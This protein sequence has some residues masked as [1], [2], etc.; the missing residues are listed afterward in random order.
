MSGDELRNVGLGGYYYT[1]DLINDFGT[2]D[3]NPA[4]FVFY[5][6][7]NVIRSGNPGFRSDGCTVR[8][9]LR[10][11]ASVYVSQSSSKKG[12]I[13][14][15]E[16]QYPYSE[17][18]ID[19]HGHKTVSTYHSNGL[20]HVESDISCFS[21]QGRGKCGMCQG[22]GYFPYGVCTS[23]NGNGICRFCGGKG[24]TSLTYD[25]NRN[26]APPSSGNNQL[27]PV[28]SAPPAGSILVTCPTCGGSGKGPDEKKY[29]VISSESI[30]CSICREYS[31]PHSH[32][33]SICRT[34]SG[35]GKILR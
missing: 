2:S 27:D 4:Q 10:S 7:N 30:W 5:T 16:K 6:P 21:C 35:S 32:G 1:A 14:K 11:R 31:S 24:V 9:I 26:D 33:P 17:T 13:D 23:C 18:R 28:N 25:Y 34:C 12:G 8:P 29:T 22:L 15:G 19:E 3:D 20:V